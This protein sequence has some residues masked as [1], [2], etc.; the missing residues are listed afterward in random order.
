MAHSF[1]AI[2]APIFL[3]VPVRGTRGVAAQFDSPAVRVRIRGVVDTPAR[4]GPQRGQYALQRALRARI[5]RDGID[6]FEIAGRADPTDLVWYWGG[7]HVPE[8]LW[9]E[10]HGGPFVAGPNVLF[11]SSRRPCQ[12]PGE[13][14]VCRSP[15]CRLLFTE[16]AWYARLIEK[17]LRPANT[18]PIVLWPYPIDPQPAGP[19]KA[20][21]D[22]LIYAK[23][24]PADRLIPGLCRRF[25]R[26]ELLRY[27]HFR[28][29][30]L[31]H[32]ARRARACVYL[33]VD[34]RG[35]L[36]LAEI[37]LAGC[38]AV[39]IERGA[40]WIETGRTGVRIDRLTA[41]EVHAGVEQVLDGTLSRE[42]VRA[43]ALAMFDTDRTLDVIFDA[44]DA[45]RRGLTT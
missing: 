36:G 33:S 14:E 3:R 17:H 28:R 10:R 37:L 7:L 26:V 45:A 4:S 29:S 9:W 11:Q 32:R 42:Q 16:S 12:G 41:A 43:E 21:Y 27:G 35:P 6:W 30:G 22:L 23:S 15:H 19:L 39:G 2:A 18:A 5:E 40:P 1:C 13:L 31:I 20:K 34:D 24:G 8:L 38:P 44:L 25:G